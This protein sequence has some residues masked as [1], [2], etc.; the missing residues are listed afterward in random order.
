MPQARGQMVGAAQAATAGGNVRDSD[1]KALTLA[2]RQLN[3]NQE[4]KDGVQHS[5]QHGLEIK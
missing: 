2:S 3:E 4:N 1:M 5:M